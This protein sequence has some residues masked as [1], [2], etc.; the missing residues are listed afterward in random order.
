VR[1]RQAPRGC[2][3]VAAGATRGD[4]GVIEGRAGKVRRALVAA[5]ARQTGSRMV[6]RLADRDRAIV[7]R[8]AVG[9]D[10]GMID[11]DLAPLVGDVALFAEIGGLRM[12]RGLARHRRPI[13]AGGAE[14]RR[15]LET[16]ADMAGTTL[17]A[18]M[19]AGERIARREKVAT[20]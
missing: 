2:A 13:V 16:A 20:P 6:E 14:A 7:A 11:L 18:G 17:D 5:F 10:G 12:L 15:A 9:H 4:A 3:V 19:G 1:W 8:D